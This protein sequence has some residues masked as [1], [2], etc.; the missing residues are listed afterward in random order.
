[1]KRERP[2]WVPPLYRYIPITQRCQLLWKFAESVLEC[3]MHNVLSQHPMPRAPCPRGTA[4]AEFRHDML[5]TARLPVQRRGDHPH[6]RVRFSS[7]AGSV[8]FNCGFR[9]VQWRFQF[10][11]GLSSV[12][13]WAQGSSVPGLV[14][15]TSGFSSVQCRIQFNSVA[16][17]LQFNSVFSSVQWLFQ[18]SSVAVSVQFSGGFGSVQW[19]IQFSSVKR[20]PLYARYP[21]RKEDKVEDQEAREGLPFCRQTFDTRHSREAV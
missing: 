20:I 4:D 6:S 15:F 21:S 19:R 12:Q 9:S 14:Q 3:H 2:F 17:S 5:R 11:A 1:M 8:Q 7:V 18:F 13:C 16:D 10:S